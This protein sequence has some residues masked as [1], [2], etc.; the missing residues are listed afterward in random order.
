[1]TRKLSSRRCWLKSE[2]RALMNDSIMNFASTCAGP[3]LSVA[4]KEHQRLRRYIAIAH[5]AAAPLHPQR[6]RRCINLTYGLDQSV[7]W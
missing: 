5:T 3:T 7:I 2:L 4:K 6:L 1:M